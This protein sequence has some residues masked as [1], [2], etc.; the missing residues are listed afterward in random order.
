VRVE[1]HKG[2]RWAYV[3][4]VKCWRRA[5]RAALYVLGPW[6]KQ[7]CLCPCARGSDA[8]GWGWMGRGERRTRAS[9]RMLAWFGGTRA[10]TG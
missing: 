5:P 7:R 9:R 1:G 6:Q 2:P 8:E 10:S 4:V 3:R